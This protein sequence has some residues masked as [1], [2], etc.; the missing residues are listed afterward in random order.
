MGARE[1]LV[2]QGM[3]LGLGIEIDV[4]GYEVV[5][6]LW[7]RGGEGTMAVRSRA[8]RPCMVCCNENDMSVECRGEVSPVIVR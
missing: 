1:Y 2:S 4:E 6:G 7:L 5:R 8:R 3:G